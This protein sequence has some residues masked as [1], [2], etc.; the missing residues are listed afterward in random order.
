MK[1]RHPR[2]IGSLISILL[3]I[4]TIQMMLWWID[5]W[6]I[7]TYLDDLAIFNMNFVP[8]P[9]RG[10]VLPPGEYRFTRWTATVDSTSMRQVPDTNASA[11]C[12]IA[13]VGDSVTFGHGV[14]DAETWTNLLAQVHPEIH[15]INAG[16]NGYNI[17][18]ARMTIDSFEADGYLYVMISDDANAPFHPWEYKGK[19]LYTFENF[20]LTYLWYGTKDPDPTAADYTLFDSELSILRQNERVEIIGIEGDKVAARAGIPTAKRWTHPI[21]FSDPHANA[22]GNQEIA[23]DLDP[24]IRALQARV[25]SES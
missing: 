10:Y 1:I 24:V 21:S 22:I 9:A 19:P 2:I 6:G 5:P 7:R 17:Q 3:T 12:T 18:N 15:F 23:Q 4:I 20:I 25:C 11:A 14:N 13:T 16:Y 8:S